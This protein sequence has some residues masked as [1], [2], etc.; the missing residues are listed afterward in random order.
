MVSVSGWCC[1]GLRSFLASMF[2]VWLAANVDAVD[3][4]RVLEDYNDT[5]AWRAAPSDGV[6]LKFATDE[7][8]QGNGA[9]HSILDDDD[10][11]IWHSKPNEL[12]AWL[13]ID[14]LKLREYEGFILSWDES[15]FAVDYNVL[16]SNEG[17]HWT[18]A[19]TVRGGDGAYDYLP[20]PE[21]ESRF[22]RRQ[23]KANKSSRIQT[24]K[25]SYII[26]QL[27]S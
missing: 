15:A 2:V 12:K 4:P 7:G 27:I 13:Q 20:L 14:F 10:K 18:T 26:Y 17:Q 19:Y 24:I 1:A 6:E 11:N 9:A 21:M 3:P 23:L 8:T 25:L 22:A 5:S 16:I